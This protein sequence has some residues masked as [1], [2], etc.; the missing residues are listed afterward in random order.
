MRIAGFVSFGLLAWSQASAAQAQD[1][2][3]LEGSIVSAAT[4]A[5]LDSG[6]VSVQ[7]VQVTRRSKN[8]DLLP[9]SR[10]AVMDRAHF[11]VCDLPVNAPVRVRVARAGYHTVEGDV[12]L[13][14]PAG[15]RRDFHLVL[16][17]VEKGTGVISG[18]VVRA[19]SAP[20]MSGQVEVRAIDRPAKIVDG[21]FGIDGIP[22]GTWAVEA[23]ALGYTPARILVD[24]PA[25]GVASATIALVERAQ[26]L[27]G[28]TITAVSKMDIQTLNYVMARK[29]VGFGTFVLPGDPRLERAHNLSDVLKMAP[30]FHLRNDDTLEARANGHLRCVPTIYVDGLRNPP[31]VQIQ[32]AIAVAGFPD[33]AGVP[34]E[35]RDSR[36]CAVIL[37]WMK[38]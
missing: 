3:C 19:D 37:V 24:V 29:K 22:A 28:M 11:R 27:E 7:W 30:G 34:V 26:I 15:L 2:P 4:S 33:M 18:R 36:S 13:P 5:P 20:V 23:R 16:K 25:D 1:S 35:Y 6:S 10:T 21:R 12:V 9:V 31:F 32:D 14:T 38:R 8:Y 17:S